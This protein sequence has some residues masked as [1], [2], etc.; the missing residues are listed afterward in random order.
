M[1]IM[2]AVEAI[3]IH[4]SQ[5]PLATLH[6]YTDS[7]LLINAATKWL[8]KWKKNN[9]IKSDGQSVLN[10]DLWNELDKLLLEAKVDFNHVRGH[11][12]DT[13]NERVDQLAVLFSKGE[14]PELYRG[15]NDL[16]EDFLNSQSSLVA[17][18]SRKQAFSHKYKQKVS[19]DVAQVHYAEKYPAY[20]VIK[21]GT[22]AYYATWPECEA[23]TKGVSGV[24]Y[25]KVKN[26]AE[27]KSFLQ[28]VLQ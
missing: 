17:G 26:L 22:I 12:G 6:L 13:C 4:L 11:S 2:A 10:Q 20:V 24:K 3:R 14:K 25:K 15:S 23:Q 27:L 16:Y 19:L 7:T 8:K 5:N 9:W 21:E 1:E 28:Q 18:E